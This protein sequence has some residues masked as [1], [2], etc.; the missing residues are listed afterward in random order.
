M[1]ALADRTKALEKGG[2]SQAEI[3]E[4]V[5]QKRSAL[6]G[7]GFTRSEIDKSLGIPAPNETATRSFWESASGA[8]L[9]GARKRH[10]AMAA[11]FFAAKFITGF[12]YLV[13]GPFLDLIG[14]EAGTLPGEVPYSVILGLRIIMGPALALLMVI[15]VWMAL[16]LNMSKADHSA[17]RDALGARADQ[18]ESRS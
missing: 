3:D 9:A 12:G 16:R 2:F 17:V 15:P 11:A 7:A 5:A 14:L 6:A 4:W 13:A 1:S 8:L 18:A 10:G